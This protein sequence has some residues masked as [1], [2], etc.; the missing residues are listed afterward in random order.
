MSD[1]DTMKAMLDK[2]GIIYNHNWTR[3]GDIIKNH[4]VVYANKD[5][6]RFTFSYEGVLESVTPCEK[7]V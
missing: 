5:S 6:T 4:L 2:S 7:I 3:D 1:L